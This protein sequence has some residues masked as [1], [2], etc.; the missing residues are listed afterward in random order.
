MDGWTDGQT[1]QIYYVPASLSYTQ[2]QRKRTMISLASPVTQGQVHL[3]TLL[4]P[5]NA[6][7]YGAFLLRLR[8]GRLI[9]GN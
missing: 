4:P 9:N 6:T 2:S 7:F 1:D 3:H 8:V 5:K